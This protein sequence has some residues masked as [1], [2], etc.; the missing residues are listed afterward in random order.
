MGEGGLIDC[1]YLPITFDSINQSIFIIMVNL[2]VSARLDHEV[3]R[4][5]LRYYSGYF[6]EQLIFKSVHLK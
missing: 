2:Y 3:P 1:K 5:L 6:W 4:Y